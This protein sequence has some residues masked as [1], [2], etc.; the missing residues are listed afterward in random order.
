MI[1]VNQEQLDQVKYLL[2]R[3]AQGIHL[4]FDAQTIHRIASTKRMDGDKERISQAEKLL[5]QM[6]LC[7][8]ISGKKAFLESLAP[9][10]HDDVAR[11]YFNIVQNSIQEA[12]GFPQ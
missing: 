8:T 1:Y 2:E 12:Q 6:I 7:P 4:L 5:E 10:A 9:E 3:S 11:I